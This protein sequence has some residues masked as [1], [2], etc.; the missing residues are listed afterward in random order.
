MRVQTFYPKCEAAAVLWAQTRPSIHLS[1]TITRRGPLKLVDVTL[2]ITGRRLIVHVNGLLPSGPISL[3]LQFVY[4]NCLLW[5]ACGYRPT[6]RWFLVV[7]ESTALTDRCVALNLQGNQCNAWPRSGPC[8]SHRIIS[9][10][11]QSRR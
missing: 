10:S 11:V 4:V 2:V 5:P 9:Q 7:S 1:L 3:H 8:N 6:A